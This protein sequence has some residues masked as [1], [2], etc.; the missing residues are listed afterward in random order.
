MLFDKENMDNAENSSIVLTQVLFGSRTKGMNSTQPDKL[1]ALRDK[2][3]EQISANEAQIKHLRDKLVF[4]EEILTDA[5]QLTFEPKQTDFPNRYSGWTLT[6]ALFDAVQKIGGNGGVTAQDLAKYLTNNGYKHG[7][8]K[9]FFSS[10][11]LTLKRLSK[12]RIIS[13]KVDGRRVYKV[14]M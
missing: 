14:K 3:R 11:V 2:Y 5:K 6:K 4:I 1:E 10:A 7:N 8:P 12:D 13:E 9:W